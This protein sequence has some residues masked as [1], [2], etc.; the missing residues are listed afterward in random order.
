MLFILIE[1]V[2]EY[3]LVEESDALEVVPTSG[4]KTHDLVDQTVGLMRQV[5]DVLLTLNL[6]THVG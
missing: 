6:L 2:V 4:L 5:R 1:E 3:F